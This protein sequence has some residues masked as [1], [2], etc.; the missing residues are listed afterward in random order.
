MTAQHI[1]PTPYNP[2]NQP[3]HPIKHPTPH[4]D[5]GGSCQGLSEADHAHVI[6]VLLESTVSAVCPATAVQTRQTWVLVTH[7]TTRMT[8]HQRAHACVL[9]MHL[10]PCTKHH[11]QFADGFVRSEYIHPP[12]MLGRMVVLGKYFII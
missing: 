7:A 2:P 8:A 9:C 5:A 6:S 1:H 11:S 3:P 12:L 10:K 4:L